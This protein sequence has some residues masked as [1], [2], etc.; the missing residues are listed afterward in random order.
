MF[1]IL[2]YVILTTYHL[3]TPIISSLLPSFCCLHWS[4]CCLVYCLMIFICFR[5][6]LCYHTHCVLCHILKTVLASVELQYLYIFSCVS[7]VPHVYFVLPLSHCG[8]SLNFLKIS[9]IFQIFKHHCL[10]SLCLKPVIH[11][12]TCVTGNFASVV[13]HC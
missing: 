2:F 6:G 4:A 10:M 12:R 3:C 5:T 1:P 7:L 8:C 11:R 13:Y 9:I